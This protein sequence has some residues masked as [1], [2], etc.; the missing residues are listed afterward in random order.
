MDLEKI[1]LNCILKFEKRSDLDIIKNY[2]EKKH[3]RKIV[4]TLFRENLV[5][6]VSTNI[7]LQNQ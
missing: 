3:N 7:V 5:V 4:Y 1:E 6:F 2:L